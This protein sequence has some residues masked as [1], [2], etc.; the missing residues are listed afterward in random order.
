MLKGDTVG[1]GEITGPITDPHDR[2]GKATTAITKAGNGTWT[3]SG[4]N[5]ATGPIKITAGTLCLATAK[6][7]GTASAVDVGR[8]AT[9]DLSFQ[10]EMR[11]GK[12]SFEGV[13]QPS[14]TYNAKNAPQFIKGQGV[15]TL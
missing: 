8:G 11:I 3:L 7:L 15:L 14:G 10:G 5:T 6:S 4:H 2:T 12:L 9:L 13:P 1:V